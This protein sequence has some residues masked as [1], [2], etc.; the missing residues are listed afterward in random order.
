MHINL[1][2]YIINT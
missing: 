2:M 1:L